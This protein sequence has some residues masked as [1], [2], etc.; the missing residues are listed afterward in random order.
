[1]VASDRISAYDFVLDTTIPDK[2]EILTRMSLWWFEQLADLVPN[3]VVSTEVP[4]AVRGRAVVCEPL[5]MFPVECVA[6][7][8]LAGSGLA[9]YRSTGRVCGIPLPDG[10]EDG[11]RLPEP[12]FTPATKADLGDHDENVSYDAVVDTVGPEDAA[13]LKELT[14]AVYA[15]AEEVA[16][17]RGMLLA[18]TKL[19]FGR[20]GDGIVLGDEVL[21]PD[22]SRFWPADEWRPGH[23][24]P[25]FDKQ[26]VR[27]WLTGPESGWDRASGRRT[28][29]AAGGGRGA[30]PVALRRGLRAAD[31]PALVRPVA[32]DFAAPVDVVF[33]YLSDPARRPEWQGSLRRI[34]ALRGDGEVGTTWRDV[35]AVGARPRMEVTE[36]DP[37][38]SWAEVGHWRGI[39]ASLRLGFAEVPTGTAVTATVDVATSLPLRPVGWV[40]RRLAPYAVRG[41]L[42]RAARALGS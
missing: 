33:G 22:S 42:R 27:D 14:L 11:S 9:D 26:V 1:M 15:R 10:L 19:E 35:T 39:E 6:R 30:D 28:P 37:A 5:D 31:G 2:G 3:H 13:A 18:D 38:R 7:G 34:E 8:Y 17:E 25:A 4:D 36:V 41:D 32:V 20:A 29:A 24:Q 12:I 23:A 16:R 40:L 21:T